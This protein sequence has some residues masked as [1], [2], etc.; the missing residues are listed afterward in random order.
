[1]AGKLPLDNIDVK[2]AGE[3][4][5]SH[6]HEQVKQHIVFDVQ[7]RPYLI[8]TTYIGAQDGDPCMCDEMVYLSP[9][10]TQVVGRQ[11]RVYKWKSAWDSAFTFD[12]T[13]DYDPDG[14]GNL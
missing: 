13:V 2:T 3:L 4:L 1:M 14:D 7:G 8:F 5:Q 10:S 9:T 12:P 11:E 6:A